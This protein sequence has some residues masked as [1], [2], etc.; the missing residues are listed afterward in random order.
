M[1]LDMKVHAMPNDEALMKKW[2]ET[3]RLLNFHMKLEL[4]LET[5]YQLSGQLILLAMAF[6]ETT[7]NEGFKTAF[8]V[9]KS[10]VIITILIISNLWSFVS[11]TLA[12][13]TGLS[14]C[15]ERFPFSSKGTV[16]I[17]GQ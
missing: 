11:C 17:L 3:K 5:V 16:Y 6:S 2:E 4:G 9:E 13:L 7:T 14:A 8:E 12:Y 1:Y 10:D 15:R